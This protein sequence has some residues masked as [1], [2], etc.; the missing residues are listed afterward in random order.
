M[1]V[2]QTYTFRM[3]PKTPYSDYPSIARR[4]LEEQNLTSHRF[5][6]FFDELVIHS[7]KTVEETL[8]S[9]S[10][11]K[12]VKDCPALGEIRFF[13]GDQYGAFPL[14]FLSNIDT[15]TSCTE[16]DILP[17]MKKIHRRYGFCECNLYYYDI[18]FFGEVIPCERDL[19]SA[20]RQAAYFEKDFNRIQNNKSSLA[21][22]LSNLELLQQQ[23]QNHF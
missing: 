22:Q 12:A 11:V 21:G 4:F 7:I 5:L 10:C 8:A 3:S 14:F 6:Y 16:A 15:D 1:R 20:E 19:T 17:Y 2:I 13:D 23:H 9:G 18:D